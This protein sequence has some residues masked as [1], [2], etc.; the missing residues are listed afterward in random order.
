MG[1]SLPVITCACP[2]SAGISLPKSFSFLKCSFGLKNE[3]HAFRC[4]LHINKAKIDNL[5]INITADE[6][7]QGSKYCLRLFE[8]F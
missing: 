6:F 1:C 8:N 7:V 5:N 3:K 2:D 4:F